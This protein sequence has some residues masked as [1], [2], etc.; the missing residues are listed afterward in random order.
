MEETPL[1]KLSRSSFNPPLGLNGAHLDRGISSLMDVT[2][3]PRERHPRSP[4]RIFLGFSLCHTVSSC[5][6]SSFFFSVEIRPGV[7]LI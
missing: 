1:L 2:T 6:S 3:S 4:R 7:F 5:T